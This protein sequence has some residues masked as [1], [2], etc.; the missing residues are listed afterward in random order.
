MPGSTK[1]I[2]IYKLRATD[3]PLSRDDVST[4]AFTVKSYAR[5][6]GWTKFIDG[7][8]R[9]SKWLS[10]DDDETNGL[11]A[12]K[13]DNVTEDQDE[14]D[15]LVGDFHDF[16]TTIAANCPAGFTDTVIRESTSFQ[17]I[18]DHIKKTF[19]LVTKCESFLDGLEINFEFDE[20]FTHSQA[21]MA[22][23]DHYYSSLLPSNSRCMGKVS[24]SKEVI[25]PLA[26]NFLVREWLLKIDKRLPM[27]VKNTRGHLFTEERPT[28]ACNQTILCDQ[29]EAMLQE[30]DSKD[31]S[32]NNIAVNYMPNRGRGFSTNRG[33]RGMSRGRPRGRAPAISMRSQAPG[34]R[35][36]SCQI[37]L[38]ARKYDS[39][40]GHITS[41]CPFKYELR[42]TARQHQQ[43]APGSSA[44]PYKVL[45]VPTGPQQPLHPQ[46][47]AGLNTV[48]APVQ[49]DSYDYQQQYEYG[50]SYGITIL[51]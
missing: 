9:Y 38:E 40:L 39:A 37:C 27:H 14:T 11:V 8:N 4:W 1:N 51:V 42:N 47:R 45:L 36:A 49:V 22:I 41:A 44:A 10:S 17:W 5:Q 33:F 50:D 35:Q 24:T 43:S 28:L 18:L 31:V 13:E 25:S 46:Q 3:G 20:N 19:K 26:M 2:K 29:M 16:L 21:W 30:L 48:A 34:R 15:K 7:K 12:Y 32:N 6:H 23:K